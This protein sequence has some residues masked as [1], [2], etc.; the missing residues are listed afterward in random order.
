LAVHCSIPTLRITALARSD[1][2]SEYDIWGVGFCLQDA[3][4]ILYALVCCNLVGVHKHL[5]K[6]G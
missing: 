2:T 3:K 5:F 6:I 4:N 1:V